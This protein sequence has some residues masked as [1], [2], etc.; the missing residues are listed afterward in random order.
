MRVSDTKEAPEK[1][2]AVEIQ[3]APAAEA[4]HMCGNF[5]LAVDR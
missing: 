1:P 3:R 4:A 2:G 5:K